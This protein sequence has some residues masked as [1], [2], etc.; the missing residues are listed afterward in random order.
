MSAPG[1]IANRLARVS[2]GRTALRPRSALARRRTL[3]LAATAALAGA[4]L[5]PVASAH[6]ARPNPILT[7]VHL[8]YVSPLSTVGGTPA[9]LV[10]LSTAV[11]AQAVADERYLRYRAQGDLGGFLLA[12]VGGSALAAQAR[13][14]V[15]GEQRASQIPQFG[16][17]AEGVVRSFA[18]IGA[19][20]T[21]TADNGR[22]KVPGLGTPPR[23]PLPA[24]SNAVPPPNEGFGGRRLPEGASP[25][26]GGRGGGGEPGA[27][28]GGRAGGGGHG[29]ER[30]Q[31]SGGKS[32]G[33]HKQPSGGKRPP[34]TAPSTTPTETLSPPS[35][36][37]GSGG[38]ANTGGG[39]CGTVGLSIASDRSTCR[40]YAVNMEP[41]ESA[42]EVMTVRDDAGVPVALSLRAGGEEN[43]FW[44]DLRMGVWQAGTAAP[45]PLPA[46]LW[47]TSQD[48]RLTSLS[49]GQQVSYEI[50]LYLPSSAGNEDQGQAAV[51]D[52]IWHAQ[53]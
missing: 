46:L 36:G 15:G 24:N 17:A 43:R 35:G 42:S 4:Q 53:Q 28:G 48:N 40:I 19:S 9:H 38:G 29:G 51:V 27:S 30:H 26:S 39:S 45:D 11:S 22:S 33:G 37:G 13:E 25:R 44:N 6:V 47:W 10:P 3:L 23:L 20:H 49:P 16:E 52:L 14:V 41:G 12:P 8:D 21:G 7:S 1:P 34:V 50:E 32:G 2:G 31:G 18:F 5:A